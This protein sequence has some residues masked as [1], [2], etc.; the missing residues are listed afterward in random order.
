MLVAVMQV[1]I[2]R[3]LVQKP[4]VCVPMA[5]RL[6]GRCVGRVRMLVM[7]IVHVAMLMLERLMQMF[8]LVR[9]GEVQIDANAHQQSGADQSKGQRLAKQRERK[10]CADKGSRRE[11]STG[12]RST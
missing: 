9:L 11:I 4:G 2:M 7:N 12:A 1:R 3:M 10:G 5:M 8:V 6:A